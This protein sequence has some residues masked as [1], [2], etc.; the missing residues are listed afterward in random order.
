MP[1]LSWSTGRTTAVHLH[2]QDHEEK[3][4]H[5]QQP[6]WLLPSDCAV[7]GQWAVPRHFSAFPVMPP[8]MRML[9]LTLCPDTLSAEPTGGA[10]RPPWVWMLCAPK[11]MDGPPGAH[12]YS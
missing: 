3:L 12:R 11:R 1:P 6:L 5:Q 9:A 7:I 10:R 8:L 2:R 4:G